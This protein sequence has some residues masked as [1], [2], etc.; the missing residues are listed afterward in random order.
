MASGVPRW[1]RSGGRGECPGGGDSGGHSPASFES[2]AVTASGSRVRR[3][4]QNHSLNMVSYKSLGHLRECLAVILI[5]K[6]QP[7]KA[8]SGFVLLQIVTFKK[9]SPIA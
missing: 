7:M 8:G 2:H 5:G 1:V 9:K 6:A 4:W 3:I